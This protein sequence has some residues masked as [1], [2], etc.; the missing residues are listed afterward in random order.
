M[1]YLSFWVSLISQALEV[2]ILWLSSQELVLQKCASIPG[3]VRVCVCMCLK[4]SQ[5]NLMEEAL[6][7]VS[8]HNCPNVNV[9]IAQLYFKPLPQLTDGHF[10]Q[11]QNVLKHFCQF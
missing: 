1:Q 10:H 8:L 9:Q 11:L 6:L 4:H 7:R 5:Y 2:A 3:F